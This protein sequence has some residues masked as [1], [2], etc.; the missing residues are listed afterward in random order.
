MGQR[1]EGGR[2]YFAGVVA[3]V[4]AQQDER[5][6]GG[7]GA[8]QAAEV[9]DRVAWRVEEV[10]GAVGEEVVGSEGADLD[11]GGGGEVYLAELAVAKLW[12][13][14]KCQGVCDVCVCVCAWKRGR[15]E[16]TRGLY[17]K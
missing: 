3:E 10:E 12:R 6:R 17:E 1:E 5:A 14:R 11:S 7:G 15:G 13:G 8:D 2:P 9:P 4:A 16:R